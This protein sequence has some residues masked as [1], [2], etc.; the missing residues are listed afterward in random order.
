[1]KKLAVFDFDGT[2][3][4]IQTIPF[5]IQQWDKL[6][7]SKISLRKAK[8][9][10]IKIFLL[11]K[12]KIMKTDEFR[13]RAMKDF[14]V[15][16]SNMYKE[17]ID[18]FFEKASKDAPLYFNGA[19]LKQLKLAQ[20]KKYQTVLLS[21]CYE[22]FLKHIADDLNIDAIIG[23]TINY[24]QYYK[25]DYNNPV[26]LL[27]GSSKL[28]RLKKIYSDID[29]ENSIAYGDSHTDID[30]LSE[31]GTSFAVNPDKIL[32]EEAQKHNWEILD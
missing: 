25:I 29:F 3:L 21:G 24:N 27:S 17:S 1:M 14:L 23:S 4:Q 5:F 6:E 31:F 28:E 16:F 32:R 13:T 12:L 2:L 22:S 10:I 7:Y 19:I 9:K 20:E 11:N 8:A 18:E 15:I 26:N 30:L